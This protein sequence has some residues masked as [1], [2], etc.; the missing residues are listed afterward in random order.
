MYRWTSL[1]STSLDSWPYRARNVASPGYV[2]RRRDLESSI[3]R[4]A[5]PRFACKQPPNSNDG[6]SSGS[7]PGSKSGSSSAGIIQVGATSGV[8]PGV[9]PGSRSAR[10]AR[11]SSDRRRATG[12]LSD[13]L[14]RRVS[15]TTPQSPA[16]HRSIGGPLGESLRVRRPDLA[17]VLSPDA[18]S[19]LASMIQRVLVSA[20]QDGSGQ[21]INP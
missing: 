4:V 9:I 14:T 2:A 11:M 7:D 19:L 3:C 1:H 10:C 21:E 6:S 16:A 8:I 5:Q 13:A 20:R 12:R 15:S 17:P 18:A